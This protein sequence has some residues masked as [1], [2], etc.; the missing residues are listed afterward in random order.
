MA[1]GGLLLPILATAALLIF[2]IEAQPLVERS[3][4]ISPLSIAQARRLL[5]NHDPRR[6]RSGDIATVPIPA[7]LIDEGVNYVAGRYLH[8]RGAFTLTEQGG[9]FRLTLPLPATG[10][11]NLR[12]T[13]HPADKHAHRLP[14]AWAACRCPIALSISALPRLY[15]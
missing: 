12:A 9:E 13:V 4:A 2:A 15:G 10:F 8:G 14:P 6:Q 3:D 1:G 7:G 11:L 5:A